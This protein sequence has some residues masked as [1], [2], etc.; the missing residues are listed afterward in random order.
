MAYVFVNSKQ[1]FGDM[2]ELLH[3]RFALYF[4][5]VIT[6]VT[7]LFVLN[8]SIETAEY[9]LILLWVGGFALG[10]ALSGLS[11]Q[12]RYYKLYLALNRGKT[13]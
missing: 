6:A 1:G 2:D 8:M 5:R 7:A 9:I 3:K 11:S 13:K 10:Y 4:V 12:L